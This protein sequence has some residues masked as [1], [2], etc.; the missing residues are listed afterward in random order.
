MFLGSKVRLVRGTDNITVIYEP[1]VY[2]SDSQMAA[3]G[4]DPTG[5]LIYSGPCQV[6][7]LF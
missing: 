3:R 4:P 1:I 2:T 6:S 7:G 5:G